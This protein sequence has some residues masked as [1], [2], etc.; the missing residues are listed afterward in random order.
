MALS[1][2]LILDGGGNVVASVMRSLRKKLDQ[3]AAAIET[4]TGLGYRFR[5]F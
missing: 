3:P 4:I 2:R 1:K 5:G